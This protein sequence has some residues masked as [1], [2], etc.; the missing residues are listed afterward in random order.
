MSRPR[1]GRQAQPLASARYPAP[2]AGISCET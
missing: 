2:F 1:L